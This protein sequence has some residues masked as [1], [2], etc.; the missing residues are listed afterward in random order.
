MTWAGRAF[1]GPGWAAFV[2]RAG[3]NRPHAHHAL[4]L[5][6]AFDTPVPVWTEDAGMRLIHT[7]VL[8]RDLRHALHPSEARV[9]LLYLDAESAA[10]RALRPRAGTHE[11]LPPE[12]AWLHFD[13]ATRGDV[14][15]VGRLLALLGAAFSSTAPAD[16][17]MQR[18]V[19]R[20]S[21]EADVPASLRVLATWT[22]L[23]VSRFA[24]RFRNHTGMPVRPYLRWLRLQRA[25]HAIA[26]Q[27]NITKAAHLAGFADAAHLSRT[28]QRHFGITPSVLAALSSH[29]P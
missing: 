26:G 14:M 28:F 22:S 23:S 13:A 25:A 6:V 19:E 27:A 16:A 15:A 7:A 18:V 20:L 3:D 1:I 10:A 8:D 9:G 11:P 24:H 5:V 12:T 17:V 4:Q 21:V 29:P 2:G